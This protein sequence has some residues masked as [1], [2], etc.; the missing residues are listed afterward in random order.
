MSLPCSTRDGNAA[1]IVLRD[2]YRAKS[3]AL[4]QV[5]DWFLCRRE[6]EDASHGHSHGI[7]IYCAGELLVHAGL[8]LLL[9]ASIVENDTLR[10][11]R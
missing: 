9:Q 2:R 8:I 1:V 6:D 10:V 4:S 11:R 5:R 7:S 3:K